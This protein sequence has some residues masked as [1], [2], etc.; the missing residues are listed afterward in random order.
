MDRGGQSQ[1]SRADRSLRWTG[2]PTYDFPLL[3]LPRQGPAIPT[4]RISVVSSLIGFAVSPHRLRVTS[5]GPTASYG[6]II[7]TRPH[8]YSSPYRL[9]THA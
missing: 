5:D 2:Y 3:A 4:S 1:S 9:R 8:A 6:Y 7:Y